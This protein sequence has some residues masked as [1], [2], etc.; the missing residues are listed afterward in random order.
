MDSVYTLRKITDDFKNMSD[1]YDFYDII[2]KRTVYERDSRLC[3]FTSGWKNIPDKYL[4]DLYKSNFSDTDFGQYYCK[5]T[6]KKNLGG[7]NLNQEDLRD[8]LIT[9]AQNG[10]TML[11][12]SK[13]IGISSSILSQFKNGKVWLTRNDAEKLDR[14]LSKVYIP[15]EV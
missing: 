11:S 15:T 8:K 13:K 6:N 7:F 3:C 9:T 5:N 2:S 10:L 1:D 4:Y 14:Y 12:V